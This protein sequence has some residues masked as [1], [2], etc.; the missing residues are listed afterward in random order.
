MAGG[1]WVGGVREQEGSR[2]VGIGLRRDSVHKPSCLLP[3]LSV[4]AVWGL[5][6]PAAAIPQTDAPVFVPRPGERELSGRLLVRPVQDAVWVARGLSPAQAAARVQ[7]ARLK[8]AGLELSWIDTLD[9]HVL[10]V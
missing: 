5:P 3:L 10:R 2:H 9:V 7:N 8:I 4:A 1:S 6:Q